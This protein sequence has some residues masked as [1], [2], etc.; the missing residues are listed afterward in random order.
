MSKKILGLDLG[1]NS[2]GWALFEANDDLAP[3]KLVDLG[4]RIFQRAVEDKTPTPKNQARRN[5]RMARRILQRRA[6]RKQRMQ[7]FLIAH[8][9]LPSILSDTT[10]PEMILTG[11]RDLP[12]L[13]DPYELRAKALDYE[14]K[15]YE[16]GRVL[17][18]LVQRRG[19]QSN[20]KTLL[21]DMADDPDVVSILSEENEDLTSEETAFK[22]DI[23]QLRDEIKKSGART[24]GEYLHQLPQGQVKR[25]RS[26]EG[27]NLRT[28]RTM[29]K[30]EFWQIIEAQKAF[31]PVLEEIDLALF[32][33][34]FF[35]RPLKLKKDRVGKCSLEP[36][37]HRAKK[38]WQTYQRF[39]YLQD[40]N[41]LKLFNSYTT[42]WRSLNTEDRTKLIELFEQDKRPTLTKIKKVLGLSK[43]DLLNFETGNKNFKGN[44][45]GIAIREVYPGWDDL[46]QDQQNKL[47]EDLISFV[48]KKALKKRLETHWGLDTETA[49]NLCVTELE[50]EHSDLSLKAINKLLPYLEQGQVYS[51][52][53]V[54]ANYGYEVTKHEP[55]NKLSA[56]PEIP[57]PI[58]MKGLHEVKR[59]VNAIIKQYGKP[60]AIRLE[61]ARDLE[62]NTKRYK[63]FVSQQNKN[64]SDNQE[65]Q[66]QFESIA[67]ANR[68]LGLSKYPSH[69]DKLKYRLWKEQQ[70]LCAYSHKPISLTEL[71]TGAVE[72]DHILPYSLTLNDS[73]MNKVVCFA[74]ENQV[75][76]Q[77]TPKEAFESDTAKWEQIEQGIARWYSKGL[78]TKRDAF[79]KTSDDLD[80]DFIGSQL[81]DTRYISREALHYLQTLGVDV[82]T[83]KGQ[84][85]SWLRHIWGMNSLIDDAK[86][87]KDRGDHRH[88]A[89]DAAV[90]ACADRK[91]YN[92]IVR[93]AKDLEKRP[94]TLNIKDIHIDPVFDDFRHQIE[95][96]LQEIVIAHAPVKKITGA[97]HEDTGLGFIEGVGAVYRKKLDES[98]T[99]K[100]AEN[101]L[102]PVVKS[103]V[104][105]HLEKHGNKPKVAFSKA[106][107]LYH[108]D[109]KTP[110]KRVRILQSKASLKD[111]EQ[112]KLGIKNKN[113]DIFKWMTLG[114]THHV[115]IF[116]HKETGKF[117]AEFVT[118]LE[119]TQR[120]VQ[121]KQPVVK[122]YL[123]DQHEFCFAL[124]K[125]DLVRAKNGS[126]YEIYRV[127]KTDSTSNRLMLRK[128]TAS[129][130][131]NKT[132][133]IFKSITALMGEYEM[134]KIQ[135]NAIGIMA[136]DQTHP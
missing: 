77:R 117:K 106:N 32:E 35:Q 63:A 115:E 104:K 82:S 7:N 124:H 50:P 83:I 15:P 5:A 73:Y 16:L 134:Q 92:T 3:H 72:I 70:K 8:D 59:V 52:A 67:A 43:N 125:N 49:I 62:M 18:H 123:N 129:R 4:V 39:R 88:H 128:H 61:M 36:T 25:N 111:L 37:K 113:G 19:F 135:V 20:R 86:T 102:D 136:H 65:A 127:Q 27:G 118:A 53:R 110:I 75:K 68:H 116:R 29:Y 66:D 93:V 109:G 100:S 107:S 96:R 80:K 91:L 112:T 119:A 78:M 47:E 85:T 64:Q 121:H 130:L 94:G 98:L 23:A 40:I 108:K 21:G 33:I 114:N 60:D 57:N 122:S 1:T 132:D 11:T 42:E 14:L 51:D 2:V 56:P 103:L 89:I 9:L 30:D 31:H 97:L 101:I 87:E 71:F 99:A 17:L 74:K 22:K 105:A 55:Q 48:S 45:T 84:V 54:S 81:T 10:Q 46:I 90:V 13:G 26:T 79:Y 76:G 38:A 34:I 28:D 131:D 41:S 12:G 133:E 24:L 120:A 58:V 44:T 6:R 69:T 126:E 95:S